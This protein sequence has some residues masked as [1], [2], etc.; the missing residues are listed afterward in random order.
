MTDSSVGVFNNEERRLEREIKAGRNKTESLEERIK[1]LMHEQSMVKNDLS[2]QK[3]LRREILGQRSHLQNVQG[4]T[5]EELE[6]EK[7]NLRR[8][9]LTEA[10]EQ[11][12]FKVAD[13]EDND[14]RDNASSE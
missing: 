10:D 7:A 4:D 3:N 2:S 5:T 12:R 9:E 1:S 6:K 13:R 11:S 8:A 14:R